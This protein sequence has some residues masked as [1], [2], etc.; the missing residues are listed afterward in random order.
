[1]PV[2]LVVDDEP[3]ILHAF[4]RVFREPEVSLLTCSSATEALEAVVSHQPDVVILDVELPEMS[5]LDVFRRIQ[6]LDPKIPAIFITGHGST[7]TAIEATKLGALD[8]LFKPLE[9][10]ELRQLV[11]RAFRI[12]SLMRDAPLIAAG[13]PS[14]IDADVLVGRCKAMRDVYVAIGRVA[15]QDVTVLIQGESGTGKEL[16]ARAIYHHSD[17][18]K[19]PLRAVNCAAIPEALLESELFG[20]E[21]GA[22]TGADRLRIGKFEQTAGGTVF[23]DEIADLTP[24]AQAKILRFLQEGQFERVGGDETLTADVR[25]IAATNADLAE[26]AAAGRFRQD[27][28]YRLGVFTIELPPLRERGEDIRLLADHFVRRFGK[29]LGKEVHEIS[30]EVYRLLEQYAWPGNVRE[31]QSVLK[32]ALLA[33]A[34]SVLLP[35]FLPSIVHDDPDRATIQPQ[36][37]ET[38]WDRFVHKR[39]R[40]GSVDLYAEWTEMTDRALLRHVLDHTGGNISQAARILGIN[41]RT[42]RAKLHA[43]G[44]YDP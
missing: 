12:R 25:I 43:L 42:L 7:E 16:V 22:F 27:L 6:Q 37:G 40:E 2:L 30:P 5:G 20:H 26:D 15:P 8:Y 24:M 4:R 9:L 44:I 10:D 38:P 17:R 28:Y 13:E 3:S 35:E 34:G 33:I 41:R 11:A 18:A 31:L 39:L 29:E 1:M 32:Q 36:T 21:R 14:D 19:N 23:L